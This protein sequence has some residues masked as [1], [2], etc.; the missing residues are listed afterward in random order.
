[1][2]VAEA[3]VLRSQELVVAMNKAENCSAHKHMAGLCNGNFV[4]VYICSGTIT[5]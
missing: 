1:M 3:F 4:V 2:D 5:C